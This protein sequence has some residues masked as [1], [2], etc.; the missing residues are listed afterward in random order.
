MLRAVST[1]VGEL[2][3]IRPGLPDCAPRSMNSSAPT[4]SAA[5]SAPSRSARR[6]RL[7]YIEFE[8]A[9]YACKIPY[10]ESRSEAKFRPLGRLLLFPALLV[11]LERSQT[12]RVR[13]ED[14]AVRHIEATGALSESLEHQIDHLDGILPRAR[15]QQ[16]RTRQEYQRRHA[17]QAYTRRRRMTRFAFA[18]PCAVMLWAGI[19]AASAEKTLR[20][21]IK[22][23]GSAAFGEIDP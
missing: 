4:V 19:G 15:R 20:A 7:I 14:G 6:R 12:V 3:G 5:A 1:P 23:D 17:P 21:R 2:P 13:Y 9:A 18:V 16:P 22:I 8:G 11:F 10:D